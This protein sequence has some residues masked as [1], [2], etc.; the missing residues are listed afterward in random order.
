MRSYDLDIGELEQRITAVREQLDTSKRKLDELH[1]RIVADAESIKTQVGLDLESFAKAFVHAVPGEID[2]VDAD[3]VK[4]YFP[5]YIEDK[6]KEWAE[7]EGASS[8]RTPATRS[9]RASARSPTARCPS[10]KSAPA[11]STR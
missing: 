9:T 8:C 6:F 1:I 3:D 4:T 11:R 7:I 5:S 2:C 10:A